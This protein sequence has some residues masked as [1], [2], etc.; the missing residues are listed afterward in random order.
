MTEISVSTII[1]LA[2]LLVAGTVGLLGLRI[3]R[4]GQKVTEIE[5]YYTL[6]IADL[7]QRVHDLEH[8]IY[9]YQQHVDRCEAEL[10]EIATKLHAF[11][12]RFGG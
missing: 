9:R 10:A 3:T 2:G 7:Q 11:Q 1:S 8:D 5:Q 12:A 4:Q 6:Q